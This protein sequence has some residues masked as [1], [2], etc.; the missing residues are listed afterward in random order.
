MTWIVTNNRLGV[1]PIELTST[2]QACDEGTIVS[3][4]DSAG[5]YGG[6][7]FIYLKGVD[8]TVVGSLV[9]YDPVMHTTTLTPNTANLDAPVAVAMS[10]NVSSHWGWY[11]I[12]GA[13]VIKKTATKVAPNVPVYQSATTGRVMATAASGKQLMNARSINAAATVASATSTVTVIIDRPFLMG[14]VV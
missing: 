4:Y 13:A 1:Q 14:A 11:Q 9:Q 6:G 8:S 3:A 12:Q 5:T 10:A 2:T 7:E